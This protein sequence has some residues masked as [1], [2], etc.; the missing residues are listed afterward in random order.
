MASLSGLCEVS[1]R[2]STGTIRAK[3]TAVREVDR[4]DCTVRYQTA[5]KPSTQKAAAMRRRPRTAK[6]AMTPSA[7]RSGIHCTPW[8]NRT[9]IRAMAPR[10]STMA[11]VSR[12]TRREDGRLR[13]TTAK[14]ARAKAMSVARGMGHPWCGPPSVP[15]IAR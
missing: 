8:L 4:P 2:G 1:R 14:T 6:T 10:S 11:R 12:K 3:A 5:A 7:A 9:A 15:A 13:P